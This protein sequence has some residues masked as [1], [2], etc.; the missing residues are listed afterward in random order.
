M[1]LKALGLLAL[2]VYSNDDV[3]SE[4]DRRERIVESQMSVRKEHL[5]HRLDALYR[6][7]RGGYARLLAESS[8]RADFFARRA[9]AAQIVKRDLAELKLYLRERQTLREERERLVAYTA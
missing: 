5:R 4:Y 8:S 9:V 7:Q 1:G 6:M 2:L 3:L